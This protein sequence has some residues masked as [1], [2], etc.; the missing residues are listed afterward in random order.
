MRRNTS[1]M[2]SFIQKLT[3]LGLLLVLLLLPLML[4]RGKIQERQDLDSLVRREIAS[5]YAG[6]QRVT[7]PVIAYECREWVWETLPQTASRAEVEARKRILQACEPL[8]VLPERLEAMGTVETDVRK[9][10][11]FSARVY[12]GT[13]S[14]KGE[15]RVPAP[16][17]RPSAEERQYFNP[18]LVIG[19]SDPRGLSNLPSIMLAGQPRA[20]EPG[21]GASQ[22]GN[23][24]HLPLAGQAEGPVPFELSLA[25]K[26]TERIEIV[27]VGRETAVS[28]ASSW[29]HPS[30][31]GRFL[32]DE[33]AITAAGFTA[34]WKTTHFATGSVE[35][36]NRMLR[37]ERPGASAPPHGNVIGVSFVDPVNP[38]LMS[39]RAA[40]YGILF[41]VLT[42]GM[43]F[44]AEMLM[45]LRIHPMQYGLV[46]LSLAI[47]FLLLVALSE[48]I[49]FD[50]AYMAASGA[51]V[52]LLAV[53]GRY[54]FGGW[55]RA[56]AYT[57]WNAALYGTLYVVLGAEDYALLLGAS[58]V[59]A[60]LAAAML[61]TRKFDWYAITGR[62]EELVSPP[63]AAS[64]PPA[65]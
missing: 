3:V 20:L 55:L 26:G 23:G 4:I 36:W 51:L 47:F 17:P 49:G 30:F 22:L 7:G 10:G 40:E 39:Y 61:G 44:F 59:F 29:P 18:V 28:L 52:L 25:M 8:Y 63:Q 34:R 33:R 11:I 42:F 62:A 48:H 41:I 64:E 32:P 50:Y 13:L 15:I 1:G 2:R 21:V 37:T 46:G 9:R 16:K 45:G 60:C 24:V 57:A 54:V 53:Y 12:K 56:M 38:R 65:T 35:D 6:A 43:F 27:P 5:S 58:L 14:L 19:M 31:S